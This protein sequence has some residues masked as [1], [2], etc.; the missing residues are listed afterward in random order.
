MTKVIKVKKVA[1]FGGSFSP[2]HLGHLKTANFLVDKL[3]LD[4]LYFMPNA[5]PPHKDRVSLPFA[6]RCQLLEQAIKDFGQE[7]FKVSYFEQDDS[8]THYT[9]ETLSILHEQHQGDELFFIMGMDSLIHLN[10]WKNWDHLIDKANLVVLAR[11]NYDLKDLP[12][13]IYLHVLS[14][15]QSY[16]HQRPY[17]FYLENNPVVDISS[18]ALRQALA[19]S[20][21]SPQDEQFLKNHLTLGT[22]AL[23]QEHKLFTKA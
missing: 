8:I 21:K 3:Y 12:Q 1:Y 16:P 13:D 15:Q 7:R 14:V 5:T 2:V 11:P 18:T 4:E 19:T 6:T 22:L 23:I 17:N 9:Y 10:T 20:T